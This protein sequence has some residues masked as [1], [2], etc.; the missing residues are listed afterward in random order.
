MSSYAAFEVIEQYLR[1]QWTTT[2]LVFEN[3]DFHLHGT[4]APFV[5]VE[6]VGN[7]YDQASIG[8]GTDNLWREFGQLYL[9]VMTPNGTG[10]GQARQYCDQLLAQ[11]VGSDIGALTFRESSVGMGE[12][13]Q[14]F[15][16]YYAMTASITWYRDE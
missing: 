8:G 13:G 12:P 16:N 7:T 10:S 3:D 11:F 6:I 9:H 2:E 14:T 5:Y 1:A 4:P 15:G